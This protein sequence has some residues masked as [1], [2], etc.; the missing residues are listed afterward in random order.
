MATSDEYKETSKN[1]YTTGNYRRANTYI[2][3]S[4]KKVWMHRIF[5]K[6]QHNIFNTFF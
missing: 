6:Y 1:K 5:Q 4:F 3:L 2:Y